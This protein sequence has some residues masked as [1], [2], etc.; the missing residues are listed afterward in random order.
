[1]K[2]QD[3]QYFTRTNPFSHKA[4]F[5]WV[6]Q[7]PEIYRNGVWCEPY[8]GSNNIIEMLNELE[9]KTADNN[10]W[11]CYDLSPEL[12][13]EQNTSGV[14]ITKRDMIID[15]PENTVPVAITNPPYLAKNSASRRGL[16]YPDTIYDDVYKVCIDIMLKKHKF[17]AAIIPESFI[18]TNL[19]SERLYAVISLNCEMFEDTDC[20]VCLAMWVENPTKDYKIYLSNGFCAGS[21]KTLNKLKPINGDKY[22]FNDPNG[23]LGLYACDSINTPSVRFVIGTDI[24]PSKIKQT[25]R[26]ITRISGIPDGVDIQNLIVV[27]NTLLNE[28]RDTT[29]DVFMTS[30]KG[31]RTDGYYRRRLDWVSARYLINAAITKIGGQYGDV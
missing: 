4:F 30:F 25:S 28:W 15:Y 20:P 16:S 2:R 18:K 26:C 23:K 17:V 3:G 24:D 31:L 13:E 1:M 9:I 10:N 11:I 8:A 22:T 27:C 14:S 7:I 21:M 5:D 29:S 6:S 12:Y 19:F